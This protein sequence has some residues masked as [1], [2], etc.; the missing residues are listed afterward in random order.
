MSEPKILSREEWEALILDPV[1]RATLDHLYA[2]VAELEARQADLLEEIEWL[3]STAPS[4][5]E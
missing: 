2:R 5:E 1:E 3:K 4:Q